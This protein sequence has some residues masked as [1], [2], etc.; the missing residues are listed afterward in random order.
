MYSS[1]KMRN[2]IIIGILGMVI[3]IVWGIFYIDI[4]SRFPAS[5]KVFATKDT[6]LQWHGLEIMPISHA[7]YAPQDF[8]QKYPKAEFPYIWENEGKVIVYKV[9]VKNIT[10]TPLSYNFMQDVQAMA[11]PSYWGNGIFSVNGKAARICEPGEEQIFEAAAHIT[12]AMMTNRQ[13]KNIEK[14]RFF[15]VFSYY[16]KEIAL[17]FEDLEE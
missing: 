2:W 1:H 4:N 9:K 12:P 6:A 17:S 13:L 11:R 5:E 16:P 14:Q 15:L 3:F 8:N 7:V 10:D